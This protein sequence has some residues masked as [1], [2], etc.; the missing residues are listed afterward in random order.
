MEVAKNLVA[1]LS[2]RSPMP[3]WRANASSMPCITRLQQPCIKKNWQIKLLLGQ[4][5]KLAVKKP[6]MK[7]SNLLGVNLTNLTHGLIDP[8]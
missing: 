5:R 3:S 7:P 8:W 2:N 4:N 1:E 6:R